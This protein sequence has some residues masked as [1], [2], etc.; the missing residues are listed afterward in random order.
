M[1]HPE[2]MYLVLRAR[3]IRQLA[4]RAE[5]EGEAFVPADAFVPLECGLEA[6]ALIQ[7][8]TPGEP[9]MCVLRLRHKD[10]GRERTELL[11]KTQHAFFT[12]TY[13]VLPDFVKTNGW[14]EDVAYSHQI[15]EPPASVS[16]STPS[17]P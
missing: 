7:S 1:T 17:T 13:H 10:D 4:Q 5:T 2:Y 8:I 6:Q 16:P 14:C 15:P 11:R 12:G 9:E 3:M